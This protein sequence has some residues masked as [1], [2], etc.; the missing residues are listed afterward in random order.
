MKTLRNR[1]IATVLFALVF[2]IG[3]PLVAFGQTVEDSLKRAKELY[4]SA[5]YE[6]ALQL[7]DAL[8]D[9]TPS[10]EASAYQV[11]CLV[12]LG[13]KHE[14]RTAIEAIVKT[15]PL[16][17]PAEGL[18]SPRIRSFF[19]DVRKPHVPAAARESYAKGKAAFDHKDWAIALAEFDRTIALADEAAALDPSVGDLKTLAGGFRDLA[20][21]ALKPQPPAPAPTPAAPAPATEPTVYSQSNTNVVKP[22]PV[23][24]PLPPWHPTPVEAR[25]SFSGEIE[26][27]INEQGQVVSV[28]LLRTVNPRYDA[29]LL[30]AAKLWTF[31]P[32]TKDGVPVRYRYGVTVNLGK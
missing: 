32:A 30:D 3:A 26:L 22:V 19:D 10:T 4:A 9:S 8:K 28:K 11:F 24:K 21:S 12:A 27:L 23:A 6:E 13:R 1:R 18:V 5:S 25:M 14:A 16:Y 20:K 17:R 15:D 7:L 29:S 2:V 31:Q